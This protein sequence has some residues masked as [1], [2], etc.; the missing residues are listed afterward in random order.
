MSLDQSLEEIKRR[1]ALETQNTVLRTQYEQAFIRLHGRSPYPDFDIDQPRFPAQYGDYYLYEEKKECIDQVGSF[2]VRSYHGKHS[3][4]Q[5]TV[6]LRI[7]P[8][9][10]SEDQYSLFTELKSQFQMIPQFENPTILPVLDIDFLGNSQLYIAR[11]CPEGQGLLSYLKSSPSLT[12]RLHSFL[13]IAKA[14]QDIHNEMVIYGSLRAENIFV[15]KADQAHLWF[16][17]EEWTILLNRHLS[18]LLNIP[19][20]RLLTARRHMATQSPEYLQTVDLAIYSD[21]FQLGILLFEMLTGEISGTRRRQSTSSFFQAQTRKRLLR[22]TEK[23]ALI[24]SDLQEK[25]QVICDRALS[26]NVEQ[27]YQTVE[28][29]IEE[30][31]QALAGDDCEP[32]YKAPRS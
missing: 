10:E 14:C 24:P 12:W 30:V 20:A 23:G 27:R 28:A 4:S 15:S 5:E 29:M 2:P 16:W 32:R 1:L 3:R 19:I 22:E 18:R 25:L 21:T 11:A 31:K 7:F 8:I 9:G 6:Q 17:D 13:D 26:L